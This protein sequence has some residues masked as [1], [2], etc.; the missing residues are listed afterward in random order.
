MERWKILFYIPSEVDRIDINHELKQELARVMSAS[1]EVEM[2]SSLRGKPLSVVKN[3]TLVHV[4]G[5]WNQHAALVLLKATRMHVPTVYTPLGGLQPWMMK[6]HNHSWLGG[7]QR[8][9]ARQASAV[10]ICGA[11]ES[12]MFDRL[13]WNT[14][15]ALIQNPVLTSQTSFEQMSREMLT[16]YRKVLD[17]NAR[18]LLSEAACTTIGGLLQVGID[19]EVLKDKKRCQTLKSVAT[20]LTDEDWR[21]IFLYALDEQV[22]DIIQQGLARLQIAYPQIDATAIDIFPTGSHYAE[23]HLNTA[24]LLSKNIVLK[25]KLSDHIE[26]EETNERKMAIALLNYRYEEE[27]HKAPLLHLV[28]LYATIRFTPVD[29]DRMKAIVSALG[30]ERYSERLMDVMHTVLGLTEGF[31]PIL[32][33][34]DKGSRQLMSGITKFNQRL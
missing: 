11:L 21:R 22:T 8:S 12:E 15:T 20:G 4:F 32:Q 14:K 6:R 7:L 29:E 5:A 33:R 19:K 23:G 2:V 13:K 24:T 31:M 18:L 16:L 17:S 10:H 1:I 28:D 26:K 25:G 3:Y 34:Q 30:I 27:R 9:M